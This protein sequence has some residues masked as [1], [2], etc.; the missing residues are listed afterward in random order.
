MIELTHINIMTRQSTMRQLLN[1]FFAAFFIALFST[2]SLVSYAHDSTQS[3]HAPTELHTAALVNYKAVIDSRALNHRSYALDSIEKE[4]P[5][6]QGLESLWFTRLYRA[7][8]L[9]QLSYE[10]H[11]SVL[12]IQQQ[13][14]TAHLRQLTLE[15][16]VTTVFLPNNKSATHHSF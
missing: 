9:L 4:L 2:F 1:W 7:L 16:L 8:D 5:Q 6:A 13:N 11:L 14:I 15:I 3:V 12:Y 10:Q